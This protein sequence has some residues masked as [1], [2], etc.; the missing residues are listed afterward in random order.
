MYRIMHARTCLIRILPCDLILPHTREKTLYYLS[1]G[2]PCHHKIDDAISVR[3]LV[4]GNIILA[5]DTGP[6]R[7]AAEI[8]GKG[9][10][11]R[12]AVTAGVY[13]SRYRCPGCCTTCP[14]P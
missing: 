3:T 12:S 5:R 8:M 11:K 13:R 9:L 1:P 6:E 7:E 2:V 14:R 4:S 10:M